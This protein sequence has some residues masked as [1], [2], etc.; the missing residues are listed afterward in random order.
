MELKELIKVVDKLRGP[1]GC[2]WDREQTRESLKPYLIEELYELLDAIDED[3]PVNIKEELGDLLF[4]IVIHCRLA[5]EAGLF[6]IDDV[7]ETIVSKMIRRHP[8]VFGDM[9]FSTPEEVTDWWEGHKQREEKKEVSL[10]GGVPRTL[11]SL[12]RAQKLQSKASKVGFDW[13]KIEDV[14]NKLDEEI[15]EF[16]K[17]LDRKDYRNVEDELGDILFVLIRISNYVGVNPED[18]LKKT[19]DKFI[20]RFEHIESRASEQGRGLSDMKLSEMETLWNEAKGLL[21]KDR[22]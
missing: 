14:F 8:H 4:Q 3:D 22:G 12:L 10:I 11:P 19:I 2:P 7:I 1:N 15:N 6:E 9:N 18:A 21:E 5:K 17:A 20:L 16:K 13:D